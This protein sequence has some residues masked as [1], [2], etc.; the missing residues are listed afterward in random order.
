VTE[1]TFFLNKE[2]P[3]FCSKKFVNPYGFTRIITVFIRA[4]ILLQLE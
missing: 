1:E 4:V 3:I 2:T